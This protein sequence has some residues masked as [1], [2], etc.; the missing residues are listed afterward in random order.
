[1]Y[2]STR[3]G[4]RIT[5]SQ[6]II[7]G[8]SDNGGLFIPEEIQ[9]L[10]FENDFFSKSYLDVSFDVFK[11]F[12]DDFTDDEINEA[13]SKAYSKVNFEK[14]MVDFH[15]KGNEVFLELYH[16]PTLAFKD[17]AL[18]ILP[19]LI[20]ISKRKNGDNRRTL[21]LVATS[22][23][24]GGAALSSF[25]RNDS[26]NTIVLYPH[27]GVSLIQEMQ[28]L[29]YTNDKTKAYAIDG[30]FDDCQTF[31][32]KVFNDFPSNSN[33]ILSSANSINIGRLIPQV[34]YYVYSYQYLVN[35]GIIA[36][37]EAFDVCVPTGNFGDIFAG[38]LAREIGVP[39]K[40]FIC[41]S[42]INNVL[43][44]FFKKGIYNKNR[45]FYKSNSPAM[46][47]LVS[48]NLERLL[49]YIVGKNPD[50]VNK[51][52]K[53]LS[54]IGE[55]SL[56]KEERNRM[57]EF[58]GEYSNEEE[59]VFEIGKVFEED[60]YLIDPHTAVASNVMRKTGVNGPTLIVSTASPFKFPS[61]VARALKI[62][63]SGDEIE[64]IKRIENY[65][66]YLVPQGIQKLIKSNIDRKVKTKEEVINEVYI[67]GGVKNEG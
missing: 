29:Y 31:V 60:R 54:S 47:I 2:I 19:Y 34:I 63:D 58:V 46:D 66:G 22:G 32:K 20:E 18:T 25:M 27:G 49:Y 42:N 61:T 3:G 36:K 30:N 57:D 12:L 10:N 28:M 59:V 11:I 43:T 1:M 67:L 41:A 5:A 6:A 14:K 55:Y 40:K 26:F 9:K 52:M 4:E 39:I 50:R 7:K 62:D 15:R 21:M 35:S 13:I 56:T 37:E 33:I 64:I 38:Y 24:T 23:D 51:L 8:I 48:S 17:M 53:E 16:G 44:D 65:S 45:K